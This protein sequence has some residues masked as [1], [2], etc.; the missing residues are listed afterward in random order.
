MIG[1]GSGAHT[2]VSAAICQELPIFRGR[3][4]PEMAA[5]ARLAGRP[6][7]AFA[8]IGD[9]TKFFATLAGAGVKVA[10]ARSFPDHH[11]YTKA[12]AEELCM[13][14]DATRLSFSPRRRSCAHGR[15]Y[16]RC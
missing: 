2:A 11:R 10:R 15:R 5:A 4:V 12:E 14:A 3:L 1:E 9:P 8:G 13:E 7:L 16:R 6:V